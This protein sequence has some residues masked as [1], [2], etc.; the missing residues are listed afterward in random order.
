MIKLIYNYWVN[1]TKE[2]DF[3]YVIDIFSKFAW[4]VSLK[5]DKCIT[6]TNAF[7][8]IL[9]KSNGKSNKIWVDKVDKDRS[10]KSWFQD[11]DTETYST[12]NEGKPVIAEEFIETLKNKICK[13]MASISKNVFIDK[14][15]DI[16]NK[17][18]KTH[19]RKIKIQVN[20][21]TLM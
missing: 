10:I 17:Y 8:K 3:Y 15:D 7:Q 18:N 19:H 16:V 21:S 20:V 12:N 9:D 11:N 14:L 13:Y 6:I 2:F 1:A 5:N 4:V